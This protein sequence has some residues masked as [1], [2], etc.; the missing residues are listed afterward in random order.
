MVLA[1]G[2]SLVSGFDEGFRFISLAS[3]MFIFEGSDS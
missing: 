2:A 1:G 3:A